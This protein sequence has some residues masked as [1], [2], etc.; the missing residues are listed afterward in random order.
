MIVVGD[1]GSGKSSL[2]QAYVRN[3]FKED[4]QRIILDV[5]K[6]QRKIQ[7]DKLIDLEIHDTSAE[8]N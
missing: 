6:G 3:T 2:I 7:S 8:D 4:Q 1:S 5:Y